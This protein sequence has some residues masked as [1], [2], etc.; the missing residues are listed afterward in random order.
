[1]RHECQGLNNRVVIPP[2]DRLYALCYTPGVAMNKHRIL[3]YCKNGFEPKASRRIL[4]APVLLIISSPILVQIS[5][6]QDETVEF[7]H[8]V[9]LGDTW[10]ALAWRYGL[11]PAELLDANNQSNR[12]RQPQSFYSE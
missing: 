1:M 12:Q 11:T 10:T 2:R 8:R 4:L 7:R 6:A 9:Q 5:F 3:T